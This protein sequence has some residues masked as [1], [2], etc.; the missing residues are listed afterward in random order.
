MELLR[1]DVDSLEIEAC[2]EGD[3]K[4]NSPSPAVSGL[5]SGLGLGVGSEPGSELR[6][7]S[8]PGLGVG[9]GAEKD[10]DTEAPVRPN[11]N[12]NILELIGC[13]TKVNL[14][15]NYYLIVVNLFVYVA[16]L[17]LYRTDGESMTAPFKS[18]K[19]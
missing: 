1:K 12:F 19:G 10:I 16:G 14:T 2:D 15:C 9:P 4:V 6:A 7:G 11:G 3:A 17:L 5:G 8:G 13:S 18:I